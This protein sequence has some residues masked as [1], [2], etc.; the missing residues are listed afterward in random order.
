MSAPPKIELQQQ[1][2]GVNAVSTLLVCIPSATNEES[3]SMHETM[4]AALPGCNIA[5]ALSDELSRAADAAHY[6]SN[7][8]GDDIWALTPLNYFSAFRLAVEHEAGATLLLGAEAVSL[9]PQALVALAAPVLGG[10]ADLALPC[11]KLGPNDALVSRA[12]L[13]PLTN[14][15][16]GVASHLPMPPD[17]GF[18][19]RMAKRFATAFPRPANATSSPAF[20]PVA[21]A[22]TASMKVA[23]VSVGARTMPLPPDRDLK[24]LLAE[25]LGSM[26]ADLEAKANFWQR[27]RPVTAGETVPTE[28]LAEAPNEPSGE[29]SSMVEGFRNAYENLQEIWSLVLPPQSLFR[30]K[31]L[32]RTPATEFS[33]PPD[34]WARMAYDFL[35]AFHQRTI[36]R[37]H[38]LGAFTPLYLGWVASHVR[39]SAGDPAL[40][41]LH[42]E[43]CA[44]AFVAEKPY[45][46]SQWRWPDR[47]NP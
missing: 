5:I 44:A 31:R 8:G 45:L 3:R 35:L 22:A 7:N 13:Y 46:V 39:Q 11:P 15:L 32:S 41:S 23:E 9:T 36:N 42:V 47:F 25:V 16:F 20:W 12:L 10:N 43:A 21:E 19:L 34:L 29:V 14:A 1:P 38:L 26:F 40:A 33:F 18:S 17:A 6:A 30:I 27:A 4:S 2:V 28:L 37:G 24:S